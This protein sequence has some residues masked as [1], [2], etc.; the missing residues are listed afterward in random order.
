[1]EPNAT[2]AVIVLCARDCEKIYQVLDNAND[3]GGNPTL[4]A[5][6]DNTF[7]YVT[8]E[9]FTALGQLRCDDDFLHDDL[10]CCFGLL[11]IC[12]AAFHPFAVGDFLVLVRGTANPI[13]WLDDALSEFPNYLTG[14]VGGVGAGFW[15]LYST[16]SFADMDGSNVRANAAQAVVAQVKD[17]GGEARRLWV[18][19]ASLGAALATY[20]TADLQKQLPG[21]NV[22][23]KPY[24]FASSKTGTK[25]Y[26]DNY[27]ATVPAY[28]LV[29]YIADVVPFLPSTPPFYPL[30]A[31]GSTHNVHIIP[32]GLPGEPP[33][34]P[35]PI[36]NIVHRHSPVAY[37]RMLDPTNP[38]AQRLHL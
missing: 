9:S 1:M 20:L 34:S 15:G 26:V 33:P 25:D 10:N 18:G 37:A 7:G 17:P 38:V 29:N 31:G 35:N 27:Q 14:N 22:E 32:K 11:L 8:S 36:T 21:T 13:E 23:L 2:Y 12:T 4:P 19:A 5:A 16:M 3:P 30:N 28:D 6:P 24:F